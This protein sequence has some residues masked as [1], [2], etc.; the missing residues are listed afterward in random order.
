MEWV[1]DICA[2]LWWSLS[3]DFCQFNLNFVSFILLSSVRLFGLLLGPPC[4]LRRKLGLK[5]E[6]NMEVAVVKTWS[7][8]AFVCEFAMHLCPSEM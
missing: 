3:G 5:L 6:W 8:H 1:G 2:V 7:R 4:H